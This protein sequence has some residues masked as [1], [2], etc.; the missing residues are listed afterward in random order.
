MGIDIDYL[1]SHTDSRVREAGR[2]LKEDGEV[3][4]RFQFREMI[5]KIMKDMDDVRAADKNIFLSNDKVFDR[6]IK[7]LQ[8][9]ED[10]L[11]IYKKDEQAVKKRGKGGSAVAVR[12]G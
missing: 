2:M 1:C 6:V 8:S 10:I 4:L 12:Y 7:I 5:E 9:G 3:L 11:K